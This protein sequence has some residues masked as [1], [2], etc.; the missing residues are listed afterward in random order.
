ME[1]IYLPILGLMVL[2]AVA[3]LMLPVANRLNLPHTVALAVVGGVI[4]GLA[5]L[6]E[7]THGLGIV[8]DFSE[9]VRGFAVTSDMIMFVFV[10]ALVFESALQIDVRRLTEELPSIL[11]LAIVGLLFS[12]A[13]I[14]FTISWASGIGIVT[15]LLL[16]AILSATDPVA[17]VA[18]FKDLG[19]PKRLGILIE[20]ESLLNDATAI[21]LFTILAAMITGG[22]EAEL[23]SGIVDFVR[24]FLGGAIV[25]YI[26]A[27]LFCLVFARLR[28]MP[29]VEI[30]LTINMAF[31]SFLIA[32]HYLH[33]SG[34]MSVV[35]AALVLGSYGRTAIS[36][37]TWHSLSETWEQ[38]GFW[39]NSLI[40]VLVGITVPSILLGIGWDDLWL[41]GVLIVTAF[42]ARAVI[43]YGM[44]PLMERIGLAENVNFAF[45]TV[46]FWGG[47]RGAVSLALALV[48]MENTAFDADTRDFIGITVTCFVLFTLFVNATTIGLVMRFFGLDQLSPTDM[49]V[50]DRALSLSLAK[51]SERVRSAAELEL[52]SESDD[53]KEIV[54]DYDQRLSQ[55]QSNPELMQDINEDEW[56][57]IG[58]TMLSNQERL[59]YLQRFTDGYVSPELTRLLLASADDTLDGVKQNGVEGY[60][61]VTKR[62]AEFSFPLRLALNLQRRVG[63]SRPLANQLADRFEMLMVTRTVFEE[64]LEKRLPTIAPLVS[65][66]TNE[67]L[68]TLL[69][70]RLETIEQALDVLKLQYPDYART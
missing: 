59:L 16:G 55:V 22:G 70:D 17:V 47:L 57:S 9:A 28:R 40:F 45:K 20:G 10:P 51:I 8:G 65:R 48:V 13:V 62:F 24:V 64:L 14:G 43:I 30:T 60:R 7:E 18:I 56:I 38:I 63:W 21:V 36:P 49:A 15:C 5:M 33:V 69:S 32:E 4:G 1:H 54:A 37:Q 11:F 66:E 12:T 42:A 2:L 6:L 19:A 52:G 34:V 39:F 68:R 25:G 29:L 35:A 61:A 58:L 31:L 67:S 44:L 50:R 41:I 26:I 3:V 53:A 27:R 23:V 46:M